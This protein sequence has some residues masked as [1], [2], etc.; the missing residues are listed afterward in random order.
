MAFQVGNQAYPTAAEIRDQILRDLY[1][2]GQQHGIAYNVRPGS[3]YF[4]LAQAFANRVVVAI[5]NNRISHDQR[6]PLTATGEDLTT[7]A[8]VYGIEPRP[9]SI[10]SGSVTVKV[11]GTATVTIPSGWQATGPN[12]KKY[13]VVS[14]EPVE[15]GDSV[16]V[17]SVE[18]GA[19]TVLPTGSQITWDSAAIALLLNPA[20]VEAPGIVGG[21]D[22]DDEEDIRRRLIDKLVAQAVGGNSASIKGWAEEISASIDGAYVFQAVRG[23]GSLDVCV[24]RN[25]GDRTVT[26]PVVDDARSN[27]RAEMPG[28]VVSIN[29]TTVDPVELDVILE[30]TL[31]LPRTG[32]GAGGGWRDVEPWPSALV[33]VTNK[34]GTTLTVNGS[35]S[36]SVGTSLGLWDAS[37]PDEPV[38]REFRAVTVGGTSGA[39][40]LTVDGA[41]GFVE[42][43]DYVSA[44]ASGLVQYASDVYAEFV[45][46]GPGE[47]TD[48]PDLLP[49]SARYPGPD[50]VGPYEITGKI[51]AGALDA[52]DELLELRFLATYEAGTTTPRTTPGLPAT[53]ASPPKIIV[54]R[55]LAIVRKP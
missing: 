47:K 22:E 12:G 9:S 39:W 21:E 37:D 20:T 4:K 42:I 24:V 50:E 27:V 6:N 7:L 23:P 3:D 28:G 52:Y 45:A 5:A 43:G 26:G 34:V 10:S 2:Y 53:T 36:P 54:C 38:M 1:Y 25:A 32:G 13:T 17:V 18:T 51:L 8:R 15:N 19:A 40:T 14:T 31:P 35:T 33:K 55:N 30:A 29:A 48:N 44:G 11:G 49:R 41:I 16:A 46:L